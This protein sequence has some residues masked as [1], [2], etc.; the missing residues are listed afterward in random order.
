MEMEYN[1]CLSEPAGSRISPE[2]LPD[3]KNPSEILASEPMPLSYV[4][5]N[6]F[7]VRKVNIYF[8]I[9]GVASQIL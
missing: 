2:D 6:N 3:W 7:K 8:K 1:K 5:D 4:L 9:S